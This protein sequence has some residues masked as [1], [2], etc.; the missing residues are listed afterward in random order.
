[1]GPVYEV[2][3]WAGCG[4][5]LT[6]FIAPLSGISALI[7]IWRSLSSALNLCPSYNSGC[8]IGAHECPRSVFDN[9]GSQLPAQFAVQVSRGL[10][11]RALVPLEC[12]TDSE[13]CCC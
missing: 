8:F 13:D 7:A 5:Y 6:S 11:L 2:V 4:K 3:S 10:T 1:M 12:L 9:F